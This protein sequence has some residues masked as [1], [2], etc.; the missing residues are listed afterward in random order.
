MRGSVRAPETVRCRC[1][2]EGLGAEHVRVRLDDREL[3]DVPISAVLAV[4]RPDWWLS[5][6]SSGPALVLTIDASASVRL[7][8]PVRAAALTSRPFHLAEE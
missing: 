5:E 8:E 2:L 6:V 1:Y 7:V 4:E 3:L